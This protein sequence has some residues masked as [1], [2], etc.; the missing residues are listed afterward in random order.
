MDS[1]HAA[2]NEPRRV[3]LAKDPIMPDYDA[4]YI[5]FSHFVRVKCP[6]VYNFPAQLPLT[7]SFWIQCRPE[8][9]SGDEPILVNYSYETDREKAQGLGP[10]LLIKN[11]ANLKVWV[12]GSSWESGLT[13]ADGEWHHIAFVFSASELVPGES[14]GALQSKVMLYRDGRLERQGLL[15]LDPGFQFY[16]GGPFSVGFPFL[17]SQ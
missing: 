11:P 9:Y 13:A 7:I 15:N 10:R 1:F 3:R 14:N 12:G 5:D 17:R 16:P 6:H 4:N 2:R 8:R